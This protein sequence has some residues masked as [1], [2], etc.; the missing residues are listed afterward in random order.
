MWSKCVQMCEWSTKLIISLS[1]LI[2]FLSKLFVSSLFGKLGA[3]AN[4]NASVCIYTIVSVNLKETKTSSSCDNIF[5]NLLS[6][7][8]WFFC[9]K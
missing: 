2:I 1:K 7:F 4:N 9:P 8:H 5:F 3:N 6:F